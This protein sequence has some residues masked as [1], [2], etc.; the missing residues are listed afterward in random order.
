[1][2]CKQQVS[3]GYTT[4]SIWLVVAF[5]SL[6]IF[7]SVVN[8]VGN[9]ASRL[10]MTRK[11]MLLL[12]AQSALLT[13]MDITTDGFGFMLS[14]GD[15]VWVPWTYSLQARYLAAH[16]NHL[17]IFG[18]VGVLVVHTIGYYIFRVSNLEKNNFRKGH[19]PKSMFRSISSL[20]AIRAWN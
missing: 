5:H 3:F 9:I 11:L 20:I 12:L 15:L 7:D 16:P 10:S 18:A 1:M 6:Y 8:E 14:V 4:A 19:N 2:I 13:T 17:G